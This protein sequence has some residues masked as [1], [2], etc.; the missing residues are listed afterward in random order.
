MIQIDPPTKTAG[1]WFRWLSFLEPFRL[2]SGAFL[3]L[4]VSGR[5]NSVDGPGEHPTPNDDR[6][7]WTQQAVP[8]VVR[9][10]KSIENTFMKNSY[11]PNQKTPETLNFIDSEDKTYPSYLNH[12][13]PYTAMKF[14]WNSGKKRGHSATTSPQLLSLSF[15][16]NWHTLPL[17]RRGLDLL[18]QSLRNLFLG[19]EFYSRLITFKDRCFQMGALTTNSFFTKKIVQSLRG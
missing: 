8:Q 18:K 17:L 2:F 9:I 14:Q 19:S 7:T 6:Q 15:Q 13:T 4:L 1:V 10:F 12:C 3:L 11:S 16:S 5:V